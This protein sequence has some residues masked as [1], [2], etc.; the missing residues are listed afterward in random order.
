M[1][2]EGL[3]MS[4]GLCIVGGGASHPIYF[5][6]SLI[7]TSSA[8]HLPWADPVLHESFLSFYWY[9]FCKTPP[10]GNPSWVLYSGLVEACH[11]MSLAFGT[12]LCFSSACNTQRLSL[13]FGGTGFVSWWYCLH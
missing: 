1:S 5:I 4:D 13:R 7:F 2:R 3:R 6:P 8:V 11:G 10:P 12:S 9:H